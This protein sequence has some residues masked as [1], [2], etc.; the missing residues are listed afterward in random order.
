MAAVQLADSVNSTADVCCDICSCTA[1]CVAFSVVHGANG[2]MSS[3]ELKTT[4]KI[5]IA[6]GVTTGL[7]TV[8]PTP[9]PPLNSQ[10]PATAIPDQVGSKARETPV[11]VVVGA[12]TGTLCVVAAL[13][14]GVML[15]LQPRVPNGAAG[16]LEEGEGPYVAL[17]DGGLLSTRGTAKSAV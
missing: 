10:L 8:I 7:L 13:V 15:L 16:R 6:P 1:G 14:A 11:A 2:A 3:C 5:S 4:T 9:S 12:A 17:A